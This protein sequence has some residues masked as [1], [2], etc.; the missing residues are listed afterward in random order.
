MTSN[1]TLAIP[2]GPVN[3]ESSIGHSIKSGI[4]SLSSSASHPSGTP[5]LSLSALSSNPGHI[6]EAS[7]TPSPSASK[8]STVTKTVAV[9]QLGGVIVALS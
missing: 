1:E 2:I 8:I 9:S 7:G 6:S 5:S 4:P 3:P